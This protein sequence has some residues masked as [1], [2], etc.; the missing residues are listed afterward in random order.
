MI[1]NAASNIFR[2]DL[3]FDNLWQLITSQQVCNLLGQRITSL[4]IFQQQD[5]TKQSITTL[6]EKHVPLIASIFV[7]LCDLY[8]DL[9]H[10]SSSTNMVSNSPINELSEIENLILEPIEEKTEVILPN[11]SESM[12][13]CLLKEFN[14]HNFIGLCISGNFNKQI[15]INAKQWLQQNT[16]L[17]NKEFEALYSEE[18]HRLLFWM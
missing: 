16:L 3:P 14:E 2:L 6:Q 18:L 8:V 10:L 4:S 11:S 5:T 1:L 12:L 7:R 13:V 17:G 15:M 9:K